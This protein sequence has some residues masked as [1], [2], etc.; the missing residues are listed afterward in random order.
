MKYKKG[1]FIVV[2]NVE[3][4]KGKNTILLSVFFWLC[5]HAD[6]EGICFPS[7]N[8]LSKETGTSVRTVDKYIKELESDKIIEKTKRRKQNSREN[9][10]NLYQIMQLDTLPYPLETT[11]PSATDDTRGSATDNTITIPSINYTHITTNE[12]EVQ[13]V[14]EEKVTLSL[15]QGNSPVK[16]LISLYSKLFMDVYGYKVNSASYGI[17]GKTLKDLLV[18][19]SEIQLACLL[20]VFFA[21][22]GMD[23]KSEKEQ[24]WLLKNTHSP[25]YFRKDLTKYET[26]VRNVAGWSKEFDDDKLLYPIVKKKLSPVGR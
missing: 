16:R 24:E 1:S 22:R 18:N 17:I 23:D 3:Y 11:L 20:V 8:K 26:Y 15:Q 14:K 6:E 9:S 13:A 7:R 12:P 25:F 21:W 19:Y 2:P 5:Y 4:F 10:S